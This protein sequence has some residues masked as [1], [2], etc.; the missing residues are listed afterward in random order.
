MADDYIK[1][2]KYA[3]IDPKLINTEHNVRTEQQLRNLEELKASITKIGLIHP[4]IVEEKGSKYVLLAGQ[5]RMLACEQLGYKKI[6]AIIVND[7]NDVAKKIV[8]L[9][10]NLHRRAL[11]FGDTVAVVDELFRTYTGSTSNRINKIASE[12]GVSIPTIMKYMAY[13]LIPK[14]VQD[15]VDNGKLSRS[16]AFKITQAF[17]PNSVKIEKIAEKTYLVPKQTWERALDIGKKKPKA[18]VNEIMKEALSTKHKYKIS[19]QLDSD[20][21]KYLDEEAKKRTE[22][23]DRDISVEDIITELIDRFISHGG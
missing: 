19:L 6:P 23:R 8:S 11:S 14:K 15:M 18:T 22:S 1:K 20:N 9:T 21:F 5:R 12:I 2:R 17:W 16:Q 3:E 10:E 4:I 13:K 7:L